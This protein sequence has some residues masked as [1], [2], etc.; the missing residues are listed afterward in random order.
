[1]RI[2]YVRNQDVELMEEQLNRIVKYGI[3]EVVLDRTGERLPELLKTLGSGDELHVASLD[4][5]S[6]IIPATVRILKDL[7]DRGVALYVDGAKYDL[8]RFTLGSEIIDNLTA[9]N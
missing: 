3:D 5:F 6:R 2:A 1:M 8:E 4:R 7:H 9:R